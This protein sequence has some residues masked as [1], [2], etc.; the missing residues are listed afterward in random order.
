[1]LSIK[2]IIKL[3]FILIYWVFRTHSSRYDIKVN[4]WFC[5]DNTRVSYAERN[6]W[7]CPH[8]DQYNGFN[9]DGDYN[10]DLNSSRGSH[11]NTSSGSGSGSAT[12]CA[13][14][15][16]TNE[17]NAPPPAPTNGLCDLCNEAQRL[18]VEKLAQF[19]PKHESRF[20]QELKIYQLVYFKIKEIIS[21]ACQRFYTLAETWI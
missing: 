2:W 8:C 5:N 16:Y 17:L 9:K 3:I 7:T 13:N 18:K 15:Y 11:K 10:R 21:L 4:C 6:S 14:A 1:V 12:I 19:E 20:E